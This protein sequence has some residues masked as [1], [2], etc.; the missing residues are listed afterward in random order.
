[1]DSVW[2]IV[3]ENGLHEVAARELVKESK[4]KRIFLGVAMA[5]GHPVEDTECSI[6]I[7]D[8]LRELKRGYKLHKLSKMAKRKAKRKYILKDNHCVV[9]DGLQHSNKTLTDDMAIALLKAN[10]SKID[11]FKSYPKDWNKDAN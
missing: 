3:K 5:I 2:Q 9:W 1:M 10:P 6:C 11:F 8:S 7:Y 4:Q